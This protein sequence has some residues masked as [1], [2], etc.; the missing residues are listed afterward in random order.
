MSQVVTLVITAG[1]TPWWV[2]YSWIFGILGAVIGFASAYVARNRWRQRNWEKK[3]KHVYV[4]TKTGVPLYD[5]RLGGVGGTDASL[6][7]SALIGISSIVQ[8]I[9]Q[10]KRLLKSID[11]MDNKILFQHGFYVIVAVLSS[12]DLP[13]I[14]KRMHDFTNR[15]ESAYQ[16]DLRD[17]KGDVDAFFGANKIINEF[18]PIEEYIKD[19]KIS[20]EWAIEN[21]FT[22]HGLPGIVTLLT[23]QLGLRD[24][25][26]IAAGIG[27]DEKT[28]TII[29]RT[30]QDFLLIDSE[31]NL[32]QKGQETIT[33]Y[34]ARK[35]RYL[36]ILQMIKR[37]Q[38][39]G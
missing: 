13:I 3:V 38:G 30:L 15:F 33:V 39:E 2:Q 22:V 25:K 26:R 17:W 24:P 18:F 8:E 9:V 28:V 27:S 21:L 35:E 34:K 23:I 1:E 6:V 14:R 20:A 7:T 37:R 16:K 5:K 36:S 19:K 10:S 29:L 11:H 4:L 32:T 31:K 12:V